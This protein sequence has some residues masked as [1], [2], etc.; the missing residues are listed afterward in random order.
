[1]SVEDYRRRYEAELQQSRD[2]AAKGPARAPHEV[3]AA[4]L[5]PGTAAADSLDAL[6]G[7]LADATRSDDDRRAALISLKA[8]GFQPDAFA[9]YEA[10]F[11]QV[12]RQL[13][14]EPGSEL[15]YDALQHLSQENDPF[16]QE[17]LLEGLRNPATAL[18]APAAALQMLSADDHGAAVSAARDVLSGS[19]DTDAREAALGVLATDP[20]AEDLVASIMNDKSEFRAV[21]QAGAVAL[22]ALNPTAFVSAAQAIADDDGDYD[23]IREVA[24]NGL[25]ITG[26]GALA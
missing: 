10:R 6:L 18:V 14:V 13:A 9:P 22:Q 17:R 7:V 25:R 26:L 24:R 12:L 2:A 11:R 3:A 8:A 16:V 21:R 20:T 19:S 5:A 4:T 23:D 1:M 15:R